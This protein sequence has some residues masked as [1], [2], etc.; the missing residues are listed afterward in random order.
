M[1]ETT[2]DTPRSQNPETPRNQINLGEVVTKYLQALQRVYDV[3]TFSLAGQRLLNES[4]Y[5]AFSRSNRIMPSQQTRMDFDTAREETASWLLKQTFNESLGLLVLFLDDVRTICGICQWKAK[6]GRTESDLQ[7]VLQEERASFLRLDLPGK[8]DH[9]KSAYGIDSQSIEHVRS[10]YKARIAMANKDS[11]VS[12][13][14]VTDGT[15]TLKLRSVQLQAAPA[16][17]GGQKGA[18]VVTS[19]LSDITR[20]FSVGQEIKLNKNEHIASILTI[21]FFITS[22]AES[23]RDY[24]QKLGVTDNK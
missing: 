15:L 19:E 4:E 8:I 7:R 14:D 11:V 1:K 17:N 16:A 12:E 21:A 3:M 13:K 9:L 22:M 6:E 18:V 20:D 10:L 23:L 5:E 2:L 24:A